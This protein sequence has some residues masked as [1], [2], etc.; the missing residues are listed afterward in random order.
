MEHVYRGSNKIFEDSL[1]P[2][3]EDSLVAPAMMARDTL[4]PQTPL[5]LPVASFQGDCHPPD[6]LHCLVALTCC[7]TLLLHWPFHCTAF[8]LHCL[9][10]VLPFFTVL[11]FH[12]ASLFTVLA[13]LQ[14]W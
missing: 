1:I 11:L 3:R 9:F 6:P 8:S 2:E 12:C 5:L 10:A 13:F 4:D 14:V 7:A